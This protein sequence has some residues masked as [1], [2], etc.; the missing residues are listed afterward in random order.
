MLCAMESPLLRVVGLIIGESGNVCRSSGGSIGVLR[1]GGREEGC[2]VDSS[3]RAL[4]VVLDHS[5]VGPQAD[6]AES[7]LA[8]GA[9]SRVA[10]AALELRRLEAAGADLVSAV[11]RQHWYRWIWECFSRLHLSSDRRVHTSRNC[12]PSRLLLATTCTSSRL[13]V[14]LKHPLKLGSRHLWQSQRLE[15]APNGWG[16][17]RKQLRCSE[18]RQPLWASMGRREDIFPEFRL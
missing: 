6:V 3:L 5:A 1:L 12:T 14:W 2:D 10:A 13:G 17:H 7:D 4:P 18:L 8:G 11:N 16:D 15:G 9:L